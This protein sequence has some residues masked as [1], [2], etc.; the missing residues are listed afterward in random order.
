MYIDY[1]CKKNKIVQK[2]YLVL[3]IL[4]LLVVSFYLIKRYLSKISHKKS[5][6]KSEALNIS[7]EIIERD[8][9]Y[10]KSKSAKPML[11]ISMVSMVMLFA[12]FTSAIIVSKGSNDN[13]IYFEMP[14][15]FYIS[16]IVILTSSGTMYLAKK[17]IEKD[18]N[19]KAF[20]FLFI[21]IIL[22]LLFALS[23]FF[24]WETLIKSNVFFT[25]NKSTSSSSFFYLI[26]AVHLL[27]LLG[28]IIALII[29]TLKT[30]S[31]KYSSKEML[32]FELCAIFWHFL[33]ILWVY[34]FLF[35]L[36]II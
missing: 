7:K 21:T 15:W 18:N 20:K 32:G 3:L 29:T 16:T 1:F 14:I 22:G 33:D 35:F 27:H 24:V 36:Y 10:H 9:S 12:G 28:G 13:W 6:K 31:N 5:Q 2:Q 26:I 19:K 4:V 34:L 30:S 23:Q 17:S 8:L 11:W 25:G